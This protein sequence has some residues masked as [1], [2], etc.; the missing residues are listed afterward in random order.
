MEQLKNQSYVDDIGQTDLND[1]IMAEKTQQADKIIN[2]ANMKVKKWIVSGD[3]QDEVEVGDLSNCLTPEEVGV[4][5]VLEII[6]NPRRD[7][8]KISVRINLS[9]LKKS[10]EGPD[11]SKAELLTKLV[12]HISMR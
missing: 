5:G 11:L 6:W 9:P 10:Q 4:E 12:E 7:S 3:N 2:H 1:E 8:F